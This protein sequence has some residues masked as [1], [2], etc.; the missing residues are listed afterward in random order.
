MLWRKTAGITEKAKYILADKNRTKDFKKA[1]TA[2]D[3]KKPLDC[4]FLKAKT[5]TKLDSHMKGRKYIKNIVN[6]PKTIPF[7]K[8]PKLG[9]NIKG[10]R[11]LKG[12]TKAPK[13]KQAL[14]IVPTNIWG[15]PKAKGTEKDMRAKKPK[16]KTEYAGN[17]NVFVFI[18]LVNYFS[19]S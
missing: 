11:R 15:W 9:K 10:S 16:I 4:S 13:N 14:T 3:I 2:K 1:G 12:K 5:N 6:G 7:A 8:S 17:D 18:L 19:F